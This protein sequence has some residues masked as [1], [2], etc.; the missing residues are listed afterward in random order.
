M[1]Q[2]TYE[3][4]I[5]RG[6]LKFAVSRG[7]SQA[8]LAEASGID[9]ADLEDPDRRVPF[10][11][12]VR[13]MH[14]AKRLTGDPALALRYA[15]H[16]DFSEISVVGLLANASRDM[17]E[18]LAQMNRYGRIAVEVDGVG[19]AADRFV[20]RRE[21]DGSWLIDQRQ[22]PNL[23]PELTETT[24]G[25]MAWG[26]RQFGVTGF[27]QAV[28]V[29]HPDPGYPEVYQEIFGAPVTFD[30]PRNALRLNP[31]FEHHPVRAMPVYVFGV[32]SERA[33]ALLSRLETSDTIRGRV[34]ALLMPVLHRGEASMDA[35][36]GHLGVSRQTLFRKLKAEGVTFEKVFDDLRHRLALHYLANPKVSVN[37][38]AYLVGF[39]EPAA[40]SRAFK[41]WTG[42][43]PSE[44]RA[45]KPDAA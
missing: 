25:R 39:S 10:G 45:R 9:P 22:N 31:A 42:A 8:A 14:A 4:G 37:E 5:V 23:F 41:R 24:F 20:L 40:F 36:A 19:P 32:L 21:A 6:L 18:A 29:T 3:A 27:V 38:T 7:A 30:A 26:P 17:T 44:F 15:Q 11:D 28:Q 43:S 12:Y 16:V 2:R 34:E 1:S 35:V 33:Q 13:L